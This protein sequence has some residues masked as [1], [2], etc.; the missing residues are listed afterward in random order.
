MFLRGPPSSLSAGAGVVTTAPRMVWC[1]GNVTGTWSLTVSRRDLRYLTI[2]SEVPDLGTGAWCPRM[3]CCGGNVTGSWRER[4]GNVTGTWLAVT[5]TPENVTFY[6][7]S[8]PQ[9]RCC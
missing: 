9:A 5:G 1:G 6:T 7:A 4:D 8:N 2:R 3:L